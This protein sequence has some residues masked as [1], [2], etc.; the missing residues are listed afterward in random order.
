MLDMG[1]VHC[2]LWEFGLLI[3]QT[4]YYD[5][6]TNIYSAVYIKSLVNASYN[7][8]QTFVIIPPLIARF[9]GAIWDRQN[10]GGP[11]VG[12]VNFAIWVH[13]INKGP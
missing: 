1:Q 6:N 11:H 3:N 9:I 7:L 4:V 8:V 5:V 2:G 13:I 12:P 10:L